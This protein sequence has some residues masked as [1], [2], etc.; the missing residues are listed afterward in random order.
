MT[1]DRVAW[2]QSIRVVESG[3]SW[4]TVG[5][6]VHLLYVYICMYLYITIII[7]MCVYC[8][9]FVFITVISVY[10]RKQKFL[11]RVRRIGTFHVKKGHGV[12]Y[13]FICIVFIHISL[14]IFVIHLARVFMETVS[15]IFSKYGHGLRTSYPPPRPCCKRVILD[16]FG[17]V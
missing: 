8:A 4:F 9:F 13:G 10:V 3:A 11:I 5:Q 17:L 1:S 6:V 16:M 14:T 2:R 15:V 7:C 12:R